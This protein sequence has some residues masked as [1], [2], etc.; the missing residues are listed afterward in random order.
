MQGADGG[1]GSLAAAL[2]HVAPMTDIFLRAVRLAPRDVPRSLGRT[3][4]LTDD[5]AAAQALAASDGP[6]WVSRAPTLTSIQ[7]L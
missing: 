5:A 6:H 2:E 1:A 7:S 4:P 3:L